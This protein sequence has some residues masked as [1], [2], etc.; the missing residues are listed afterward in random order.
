MRKEKQKIFEELVST[1]E[2]YQR[3]KRAMV[4]V[5][6]KSNKLNKY[7]FSPKGKQRYLKRIGAL[8]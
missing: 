7:H 4:E 2:S 8:S 5:H 6:T 1:R 3:E